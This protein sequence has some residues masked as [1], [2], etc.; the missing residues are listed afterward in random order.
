[1]L[2]LKQAS[3]FWEKKNRDVANSRY[4]QKHLESREAKRIAIVI[5]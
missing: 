5:L 1:M 2:T 4:A 3:S